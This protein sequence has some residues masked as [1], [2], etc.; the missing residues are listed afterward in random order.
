MRLK[1]HLTVVKCDQFRFDPGIVS[2]TTIVQD[3]CRQH[4][5]DRHQRLK[6]FLG[7]S[8]CASLD[9][10]ASHDSRLHTLET[11]TQRAQNTRTENI[12]SK[13]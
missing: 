7:S 8:T 9:E 10:S 2:V 4:S 11:S 13:S 5:S 12:S 3:G 6:C 1:V